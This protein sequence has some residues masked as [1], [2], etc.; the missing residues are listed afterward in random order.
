MCILQ[1]FVQCHDR[2]FEV[3]PEE[4]EST[5]AI[6]EDAISQ[7]LLDLFGEV[8][9]DDVAIR[10]SSDLRMGLQHCSIQIQA[11]CSYQ[12]FALLPR[13]KEHI[14]HTVKKR[15]SLILKELFGSVT[16]DSVTITPFSTESQK[17]Y[18]FPS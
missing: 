2:F 7:V 17:R 1:I 16:V 13:T 4:L 8:S 9:V 3:L 11:Q 6:V 10:F 14:E 15:I 18:S 12:S 5:E